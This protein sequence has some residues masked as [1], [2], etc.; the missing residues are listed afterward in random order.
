M[1]P[2]DLIASWGIPT[3]NELLAVAAIRNHDADS[4]RTWTPELSEKEM[5]ER[6]TE[7]LRLK[8]T[9]GPFQSPKYTR[10]VYGYTIQEVVKSCSA[11]EETP[12]ATEMS[13]IYQRIMDNAVKHITKS[14]WVIM[15]WEVEQTGEPK[16]DAA[17]NP[18][19]KKGAKKEMALKVYEA[20]KQNTDLTRQDWIKLL[21]DEVGMTKAGAST[22]YANLK[23]G[24]L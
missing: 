22:Y 1:N 13:V 17:G 19:Q 2:I 6:I 8:T 15:E 24:K 14:P 7:V 16:M 18:K 11:D 3:E 20:N 5:L 21:M 10:V 12:S 4:G 9:V 23:K